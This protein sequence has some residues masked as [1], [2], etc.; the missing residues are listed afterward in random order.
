MKQKI[1]KKEMNL[2]SNN[3]LNKKPGIINLNKK[4]NNS[5]INTFFNHN[6]NRYKISIILDFL[7][8]NE[9]LPLMKMNKIFSNILFNKYNLPFK[10]TLLLKN[11]K[12]NK[13]IIEAKFSNIYNYFKK[14]I[15]IDNIKENNE[16]QYIIS[17]LLKNIN[18]NFIIFDKLNDENNIS[19][20]FDFLYKIK[21]IKNITHIKFNLS[22]TDEKIDN[23]LFENNLPFINFYKNINHLEIDKIEKSFYFFNRMLNYENNCINNIEKINLNNINIRTKDDIILKYDDYNS[24]IIPKITNLKYIFLTKVNLSISFLN[25]IISNNKKLIKLIINHCTD[26]KNNIEEKDNYELFNKSINNCI[27]LTHIEFN[28][29]NFSNIFIT[30]IIK[31]LISL[32]FD[33]NN[34]IY[35]ISCT[36]DLINLKNIFNH[37]IQYSN[38]SLNNNKERFLKIKF[39]PSF[40]YHINKNKSIIEISNYLNNNNNIEYIKKLKYEKI[41]LCLYNTDNPSIL[42]NIKKVMDIY[43]NKNSL[44]Y[45]QIF[46]TFKNGEINYINNLEQEYIN[47]KKFTLIFQNDEEAV[48]LF[49][50][51]II[52]SILIFFPC[53]K[54]I[55]FKNIN[56]QNDDKKF[57]EYFDDLKTC[58]EL[59]LFGEK[60]EIM[61]YYINKEIKLDL[62]EIKFCNCYYYKNSIDKYIL[63][64]INTTKYLGKKIKLTFID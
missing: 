48:N 55:S 50:N 34:N 35:L 63:N 25:D 32:F 44:K 9:Q 47:I 18:N 12:N 2:N 53:V 62:A 31:N 51:K 11:Y 5:L 3:I 10:S 38:I 45:F 26:I 24:L 54:I 4:N 46:A 61:N 39:S 7:D 30:E 20:F 36:C 29:N 52:F 60:N 28:N 57:R 21:Y 14:I 6:N 27:N 23:K 40:I 59:I 22:N 13:N 58:F 42:N 1:S 17:F 56:F 15:N 8:I 41:K 19:I 49:G 16:Y 64:E 43:N 33:I 37:L